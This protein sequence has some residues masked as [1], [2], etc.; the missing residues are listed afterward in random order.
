M[1]Q[2]VPYHW[3]LNVENYF[4]MEWSSLQRRIINSELSGSRGSNKTVRLQPI[5]AIPSRY[6]RQGGGNGEK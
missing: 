3:K 1:S 6:S 4:V 2:L 5:T